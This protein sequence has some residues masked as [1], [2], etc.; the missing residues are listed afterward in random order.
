MIIIENQLVD[1]KKYGKQT[2]CTVHRIHVSVK[3]VNFHAAE[4]IKLISNKSWISSLDAIDQ[5]AYEARAS[6]TISKLV[7][8]IFKK[9]I[10]KVTE[11]F[12]E[13]LVTYVAQE[14]LVNDHGHEKVPWAELF[15]EKLSNN[16]GF[17]F[18]TES[19]TQ[20]VI[21]GESKY[22]ASQNP[23]TE[24]L[25]Q[26][27]GFI[28]VQKDLAELADVR[29]FVSLNAANNAVSNKKGFVA[30]FSINAKKPATV[31]D[32]ALSSGHLDALLAYP[33]LYLIGVQIDA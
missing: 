30:A 17:D 16:M 20:I 33:E 15:K 10:D 12:G 29:K 19:K 1:M 28:D 8:S 11:D 14:I 22:S 6:K 32:N 9:V 5:A 26:I 4:I 13:Y 27:K 7:E 18:H 23:Y 3:N 2:S 21:F 31:L 24:A 25:D